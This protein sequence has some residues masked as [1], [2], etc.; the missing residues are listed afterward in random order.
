MARGRGYRRGPRSRRARR[1]RPARRDGCD[2]RS[3]VPRG[4]DAGGGIGR[5]RVGRG[6]GVFARA[7]ARGLRHELGPHGHR[8]RRAI[9]SQ[10]SRGSRTA[11]HGSTSVAQA[12]GRLRATPV[13]R[14]NPAGVGPTFRATRKPAGRIDELAGDAVG[15]S[16]DAVALRRG[17]DPEDDTAALADE[18]QAPLDRRRRMGERLRDRDAVRLDGLLLRPAPDDLEVRQLARPALE[19]VALAALRL[20]QRDR[21]A[22]ER[23]GERDARGAAAR[24]DVDDR[25]VE[26]LNELRPASASSSRTRRASSMSRIAVRPGVATTA[27]SQRSS[28][29][30]RTIPEARRHDDDER[31]RHA[32]CVGEWGGGG[33]D[34]RK[35]WQ[36]KSDRRDEQSAPQ[37]DVHGAACRDSRRLQAPAH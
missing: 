30:V 37:S 11:C 29:S 23:R 34:D 13:R 10:P 6:L 31:D 19:E 33:G 36:R 15:D 22:G 27:V 21:P 28:R 20:E 14:G 12:S 24:P 16:G 17:A 32:A 35:G 26:A 2:R 7:L 8:P 3:P 1:R 5:L 9:A 18:R 4:D 25:A